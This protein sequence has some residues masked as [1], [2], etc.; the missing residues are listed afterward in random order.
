[1]KKPLYMVNLITY[2]PTGIFQPPAAKTIREFKETLEKAGVVVTQRL[3]LGK[4]I[5]GACGQLI[6]K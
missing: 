3:R 1:M 5:K 4:G 6:S 2:N